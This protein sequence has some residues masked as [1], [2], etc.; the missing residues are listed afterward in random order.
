MSKPIRITKGRRKFSNS[1]L[2]TLCIKILELDGVV[3]A[4]FFDSNGR[5]LQWKTKVEPLI[6]KALAEDAAIARV[7]MVHELVC[8][9]SEHVGPPDLMVFCL[10]LRN[11]FVIPI[12]ENFLIFTTEKAALDPIINKVK[13]IIKA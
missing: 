9:L 12:N 7:Q 11:V 6:S 13:K 3:G 4:T 8:S 5:V 1:E 10:E 2:E